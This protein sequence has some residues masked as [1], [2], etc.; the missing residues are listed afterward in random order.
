MDEYTNIS[1]NEAEGYNFNLFGVEFIS[2]VLTKE[3]KNELNNSVITINPSKIKFNLTVLN[4][5]LIPV[6]VLSY[7]YM[8][9]ISFDIKLS[10][11]DKNSNILCEIW[12]KNVTIGYT[13]FF[14][15]SFEYNN[16]KSNEFLDT[17][18][19]LTFVNLEPHD[20]YYN[21]ELIQSRYH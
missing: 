3:Q 5:H 12:Y 14:Q 1:L 18:S 21:N 16:Y 20:I 7:L 17:N 19:P 13:D 11:H 2:N 6:D 15:Q 8:N 10:P 4:K 9:H